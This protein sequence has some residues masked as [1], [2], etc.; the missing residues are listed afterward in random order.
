[1][2]KAHIGIAALSLAF[3]GAGLAQGVAPPRSDSGSGNKAEGVEQFGSVDTNKDG[4]IS[5]AE[6]RS[7]G[8]ALNSQF[9]TLD[10]DKD[11]YLS[12]MEFGKWKPSTDR[13]GS[14]ST[15]PPQNPQG[16]PA[17]PGSSVPSPGGNSAP[18][19]APQ[20]E[21]DSSSSAQ[22]SGGVQ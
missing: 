19:S 9:S 2:K 12:Q 1:M 7:H 18:Q 3:A 15:T 10:T 17:Q 5:Q 8:S 21:S 16:N 6:A 13:G 11:T 20:S 4:R 22:P 14:S